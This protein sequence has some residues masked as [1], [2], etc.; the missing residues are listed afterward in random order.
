M[1]KNMCPQFAYAL[2]YEYLYLT[3]SVNLGFTEHLSD[4]Y[5]LKYTRGTVIQ[6]NNT[7]YS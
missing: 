4:T 2:V 6:V 7:P 1:Y 3:K 5:L